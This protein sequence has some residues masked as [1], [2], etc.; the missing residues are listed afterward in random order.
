MGPERDI[1]EYTEERDIVIDGDFILGILAVFIMGAALILI[2]LSW[3]VV[4]VG[5]FRA[6]V[7]TLG[8]VFGFEDGDINPDSG[9]VWKF[10]NSKPHWVSNDSNSERIAMIICIK[11]SNYIAEVA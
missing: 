10:D 9:D 1:E 4:P 8:A 2:I 6:T 7:I 11:H 3:L 5:Y